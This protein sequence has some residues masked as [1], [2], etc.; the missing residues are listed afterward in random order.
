MGHLPTL[1]VGDFQ[2]A[3]RDVETAHDGEKATLVV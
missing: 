1:M 2:R 3:F